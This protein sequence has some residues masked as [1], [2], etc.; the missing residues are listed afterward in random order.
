MSSML[1]ITHDFQRNT[2]VVGNDR[3][4]L[5]MLV[6]AYAAACAV[7]CFQ[8][9]HDQAYQ[10]YQQNVQAKVS[11]LLSAVNETCVYDVHTAV[12]WARELWFERYWLINGCLEVK[13]FTEFSKL[14]NGGYEGT[15]DLS[16]Q[17]SIWSEHYRNAF[18]NALLD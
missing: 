7:P 18:V 16:H 17:F 1:T 14:V 9:S 12:K 10:Y 13:S 6:T 3:S 2:T 11:K 15:T 8:G 4:K 5:L